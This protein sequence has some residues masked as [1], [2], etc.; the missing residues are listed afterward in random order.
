MSGGFTGRTLEIDLNRQRHFVSDTDMKAAA[1]Y[2]GG[3]GMGIKTLWDRIPT[4]GLDPLSPEN[5]LM[6]WPGPLSGLPLAGTSR[7]SVVTKAANTSP[8]DGSLENASTVTYSSIGGHF[9]PSLKMAGFDGLILSGRSDRPVVLIIDENKIS[10]RDAADLWGQT[11]SITL[12]M[13]GR[14][15]GP[16]FRLLAIG[17]AGE[18]GVRF[19]GIVSDVR[20]T[21][22]RG[23]SG[24]V[25]GSKNIKAIAVRGTIPIP[26]NKAEG[27]MAL[28][29]ETA[30]LLSSWSNYTHWRRWG[31]TPLLL[32]S[33]QAG[34]LTTKN[35]REGSWQNIA[36]L[37]IPATE[38][39]F[40]VHH[41]ACAHCTLK[42]VKIG[43]ISQGPWKGVIAEGPGYSA[44]AMLGSN[45]G[46]SDLDGLMKLISRA[47]D[48]GMDPIAAGNVLGFVM[49]LYDNGVLGSAELGGLSPE[50]GKVPVMLELLDQIAFRQGI[51]EVLSLGVKK[52]AA[53]FGAKAVPFAM[54]VKGQELAGWNVPASHD[55]ALVYGT[56]NRGG[57][58]QEGATIQEQHRRTFLD[59][60]CV[61]RFVYGAVGL[62]PYQRALSLATGW[63]SDDASMLAAGERIWTL[64][65]MFNAREGF[66]RA[67]D[68]LPPSMTSIVFTTGPKKGASFPAE[69]QESLLDKYYG[70]RGWEVKTSLPTP[71]KL[72]SLGLDK[73]VEKQS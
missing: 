9:G 2:L 28:R 50:W 35:F 25:M 62:A 7:V 37:S 54:H 60:L 63:Q 48:L 65:K 6:F 67:D 57:S 41:T 19:A 68:R 20:R 46:V 73:L 10:F 71:A 58:H 5:P 44:G 3:R 72:K 43:Q 55:F 66:R 12:E 52:A 29:R 1:L 8:L 64:E 23:G 69:K 39:E 27:L 14:E 22:A 17:P 47:D 30:T 21:T 56:A 4:A 38:R 13:L 59:A 11:T 24:A 40:W 61:C 32:S 49:D 70:D 18:K 26:M 33:A 42:C 36:N 45:C 16:D 31:P 53:A 51:G 34:M 15:L